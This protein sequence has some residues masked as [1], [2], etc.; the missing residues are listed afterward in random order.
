M[1]FRPPPA[2]PAVPATPIETTPES[3]T[4]IKEDSKD[5]TEPDDKF[6]EAPPAPRETPLQSEELYDVPEKTPE[7]IA[8]EEADKAAVSFFEDIT[9][10]QKTANR[11][12]LNHRLLKNRILNHRLLNHRL[13]NHRL[14]NCRFAY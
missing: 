14:L 8:K 13:L 4:L 9:E 7:E 11:R 2:V 6:E 12:L 5:E 10:S 3:K 1:I